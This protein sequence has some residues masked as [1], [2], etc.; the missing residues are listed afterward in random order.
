MLW[1][2][3]DT[4]RKNADSSATPRTIEAKSW[5]VISPQLHKRKL[6]HKPLRTLTIALGLFCLASLSTAI[7]LTTWYAPVSKPVWTIVAES[8]ATNLMV[9]HNLPAVNSASKLAELIDNSRSESLLKSSETK[10]RHGDLIVE[11]LETLI[12][13]LRS[14]TVISGPG[15]HLLMQ[16]TAHGLVDEQGPFLLKDWASDRTEGLAPPEEKDKIRIKDLLKQV[17]ESANNHPCAVILNCE[18]SNAFK[19]LGIWGNQFSES[20]IE[21]ESWIEKQPNLVV[22]VTTGKSQFNCI[23]AKAGESLF[24]R[25]WREEISAGSSL[26]ETFTLTQ[27]FETVA[28]RVAHEALER[29]GRDQRPIILPAG[30]TGQS[31]AS[32]IK[33]VALT[34]AKKQT[35]TFLTKQRLVNWKERLGISGEMDSERRPKAPKDTIMPETLA[36]LWRDYEKLIQKKPHPANFRPEA[37]AVYKA[38]VLRFED[39]II[40]KSYLSA[41]LL[42][43]HIGKLKQKLE[44]SKPVTSLI[45]E[46]SLAFSEFLLNNDARQTPRWLV[47]AFDLEWRKANVDIEKAIDSISLKYNNLQRTSLALS[48][49]TTPTESESTQETDKQ[50]ETKPTSTDGMKTVQDQP[51]NETTGDIRPGAVDSSKKSI[52]KSKSSADATEASTSNKSAAAQEAALKSKPNVMIETVKAG[53]STGKQSDAPSKL[54]NSNYQGNGIAPEMRFWLLQLIIDKIRSEAENNI[55]LAMKWTDRIIASDAIM[56]LELH[57]LALASKDMRRVGAENFTAFGHD[58]YANFVDLILFSERA[59]AG[60]SNKEGSQSIFFNHTYFWI[61][62]WCDKAEAIFLD[63]WDHIFSPD[64]ELRNKGILR[65]REAILEYKEILIKSAMIQKTLETYYAVLER[66]PEL[67]YWMARSQLLDHSNEYHVEN[68]GSPNDITIAWDYVQRITRILQK[69]KDAT[70]PIAEREE[71]IKEAATT[72]SKLSMT[73][74]NMETHY[75][76]ICQRLIKRSES[77]DVQPMTL[78]MI[79]QALKIPPANVELRRILVEKYLTLLQRNEAESFPS[80]NQPHSE[81]I[82]LADIVCQRIDELQYD[83]SV[84]K[85]LISRYF[86]PEQKNESSRLQIETS[87]SRQSIGA[88][89]RR[90]SS[91]ANEFQKSSTDVDCRVSWQLDRLRRVLPLSTIENT[92]DTFVSQVQLALTSDHLRIFA[93]RVWTSHWGALN[94][95][96][97]PYYQKVSFILNEEAKR[98]SPQKDSGQVSIDPIEKLIRSPRLPRFNLPDQTEVDDTPEITIPITVSASKDEYY[99]PGFASLFV[100][101]NNVFIPDPSRKSHASID[102]SKQD[103]VQLHL[104]DKTWKSSW[105]PSVSPPDI[106][107]ERVKVGF[108]FR[109]NYQESFVDTRIKHKPD[110]RDY[111]TQPPKGGS[112]A[113]R[114]DTELLSRL[115]RSA[116]NISF[117]LDCSGSMGVPPGTAWND[118]AKYAQAVESLV[119]TISILPD[120]TNISIWVFGEAVGDIKSSEPVSTIREVVPFTRWTASDQ[121]LLGNIRDLVSYPACEPWNKSPVI[122]AMEMAK[123]RLIRQDGPKVMVVITDG[124]DNVFEMNA[125]DPGT[126]RENKPVERNY[127]KIDRKI[128]SMFAETGISV[129]I[130]GYKLP[131]NEKPLLESHFGVVRDLGTPGVFA[132]VD[133]NSHLVTTLNGI[134]RRKL[135]YRFESVTPGVIRPE[136]VDGTEIQPIGSAIQWVSPLL[137]EDSYHVWMQAGQRVDATMLIQNGKRNLYKLVEDQARSRLMFTRDSW[138]NSDLSWR[139]QIISQGWMISSVG[140][141]FVGNHLEMLLAVEKTTATEFQPSDDLSTKTEPEDYNL[142]LHTDENNGMNLNGEIRRMWNY[143]SNVWKLTIF[144]WNLKQS[145]PGIKLVIEPGRKFDPLLTISRQRNY[146]KANDIV[147]NRFEIQS[148]DLHIER[149]EKCMRWVPDVR[150]QASVLKP[151]WVIRTRQNPPGSIRAD[152]QFSDNNPMSLEYRYFNDSGVCETIVWPEKDEMTLEQ[153]TLPEAIRFRPGMNMKSKPESTNIQLDLGNSL[154]FQKEGELWPAP[155]NLPDQKPTLRQNMFPNPILPP[156]LGEEGQRENGTEGDPTLRPE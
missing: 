93:K 146:V 149:F 92:N 91:L 3:L 73:L 33:L 48:P 97:K 117:V 108:L 77:R 32:E 123:T 5:S 154:N 140:S 115:G 46:P 38:A 138:L 112:F 47:T 111:R 83:L 150:F 152:L 153:L 144:D 15:G 131:G 40:N 62:P 98:L 66:L 143:P 86:Q 68:A 94:E 44:Q 51:K 31:R 49:S 87:P 17:V 69:E 18:I 90:L 121:K 107:N 79:R 101:S 84:D 30:H 35:T 42:K 132:F 145:K 63:S 136:N 105:D 58:S 100:M 127:D 60:L 118:K 103:D 122:A 2:K 28:E 43:S 22:I 142:V 67:S 10:K 80:D 6:F 95:N 24:G 54:A 25:I 45:I 70:L 29:Y 88:L 89:T 61:K 128:R 72:A 27:L 133:D 7:Y 39:L 75:S 134:L 137:S 81:K 126:I 37:W 76:A 9:P 106:L 14:Q 78:D 56:P 12:P 65:Q 156:A 71:I 135:T 99:P 116:G 104:L 59:F 74:Q 19:E 85:S 124:N 26:G 102:I 147:G 139:P 11:R 141:H 8:Y 4:K 1:Q 23:D 113:V 57:I 120:G 41:A 82:D 13:Q 50:K 129:N 64:L 20:L 55:E 109:G 148:S 125:I 110:W 36:S 53:D 96:V 119:Q 21:M 52:A 16:V 151:C 34:P 130:I 155:V 114:A